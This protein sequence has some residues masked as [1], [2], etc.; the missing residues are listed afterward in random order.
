MDEQQQ[1]AWLTVEG[2]AARAQVGRRLIYREVSAGRLKAAKVGGRR[3]LRFKASWI[4]LW[5]ESSAE[6]QEIGR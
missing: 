5:L 6:P 1:Q 4:D 2:A 3:E